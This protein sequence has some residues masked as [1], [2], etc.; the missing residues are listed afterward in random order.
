M[1]NDEPRNDSDLDVPELLEHYKTQR[2]KL[3]AH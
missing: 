3:L 1:L 2:A